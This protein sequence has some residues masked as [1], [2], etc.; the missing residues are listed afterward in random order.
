M[1][2]IFHQLSK[3][4]KTSLSE[5][6]LIQAIH[7]KDRAGYEALYDM[8]SSALYGVIYRTIQHAEIAEDLLQ[9]TFVK[10]CN[11]FES[12]DSSKGKLFTWMVSIA[13][14]ISIDKI[15]SKDFR[16]YSK[17]EDIEN[18]VLSIDKRLNDPSVSLRNRILSSL[19][20][21]TPDEVPDTIKPTAASTS[22]S[23]IYKYAFAASVVLLLISSTLL[24]KL[25]N[26]LKESNDQLA[27]LQSSNQK[28]SSR[29]NYIDRELNDTQ[30]LL[31]VYQNPSQYKLIILKGTSKIPEASMIIAF[32]SQKKEVLID[33]SALKMPS[34]DEDHQ[35]QLWALVDGKPTD[36][37]VFDSSNDRMGMKKMKSIKNAQ[38]FAVTLE[39]KGGSIKP[40]MEQMMAIG[41]I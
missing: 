17:T 16:N 39:P 26:Q 31:E 24:I 28:F 18:I 2:T 19:E 1:S 3:T 40:T 8:Y 27:V 4:I 15:R 20:I 6:E 33:L 41:N 34:N 38:A 14:N 13:R 29:V 21:I 9:E 30:K 5:P 22:S 23:S 35:Y 32:N 37:G 10:I 7:R 36:L 12:Y 25:D 11:S